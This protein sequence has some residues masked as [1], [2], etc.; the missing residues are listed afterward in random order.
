MLSFVEC[1]EWSLVVMNHFYNGKINAIEIACFI[2]MAGVS[3]SRLTKRH[4]NIPL[5]SSRRDFVTVR[6]QIRANTQSMHMAQH[7]EE[8]DS[9][10]S[11]ALTV[12]INGPTLSPVASLCFT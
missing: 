5:I 12:T 1:V 8:I 4:L 7:G 3:T 10:Y 11:P 2:R 9:F 6:R